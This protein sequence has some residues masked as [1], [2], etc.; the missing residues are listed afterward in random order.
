[1]SNAH[2]KW[3]PHNHPQYDATL[4]REGEELRIELDERSAVED[5]LRDSRPAHNRLYRALT[6]VTHLEYAGTYRGTQGSSL[7]D[8][9][10]FAPHFDGT[11]RLRQFVLPQMVKSYMDVAFKDAVARVLVTSVGTSSDHFV[12]CARLFYVFGLIHP[13]LDGNGHIQRLMF[14]RAIG[15]NRKISLSTKWTV[16]PRP[17]S[18]EMAQAF[19]AEPAAQ[20]V[21]NVLRSYVTLG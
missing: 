5:F 9:V 19:D 6:P 17:Y 11:D 7:E 21:A 4:L 14:D 1:M 13:F 18:E 12:Q 15:L 8:R 20:S 16:H 2:P 10:I 3:E